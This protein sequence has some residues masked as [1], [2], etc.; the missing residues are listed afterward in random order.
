MLISPGI[1]RVTKSML[2]KYVT[3]IKLCDDQVDA[4]MVKMESEFGPTQPLKVSFIIENPVF[5]RLTNPSKI[6]C[7]KALASVH[8]ANIDPT[9]TGF[10]K[11]S[12]K[13]MYIHY[14]S[15][16]ELWR[17]FRQCL[18]VIPNSGE[19]FAR[20]GFRYL[21][22]ITLRYLTEA[23]SVNHSFQ[24][25]DHLLTD[26][27]SVKQSKA[28]LGHVCRQEIELKRMRSTKHAKQHWML[29]SLNWL[30]GNLIGLFRRM[31]RMQNVF[32]ILKQLYWVNILPKVPA[33]HRRNRG[34][35]RNQVPHK[36][37]Y[38]TSIYFPFVFFP[39]CL[40]SR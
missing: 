31:E 27:Q 25:F 9:T 20:V 12:G 33:P 15:C 39:F 8:R 1:Y 24:C 22:E 5:K 6:E 36:H 28:N 29:H 21:S 13:C 10:Q 30:M 3:M 19:C 18:L 35:Q 23:D 40:L 2:K 34:E 4:A 7:I 26:T 14:I 16:Y 38:Y 11:T 37:L 17:M 32:F